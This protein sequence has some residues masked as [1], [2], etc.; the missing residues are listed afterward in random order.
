MDRATDP[1]AA[2]QRAASVIGRQRVGSFG[3]SMPVAAVWRAAF[4]MGLITSTLSTVIMALGSGRIGTNVAYRFMELATIGLRDAAI[5]YEPSWYVVLVGIINH[6]V[7]DIAWAL[8]FFGLASRW[9]LRIRP[10]TLLALTL[11]WAA[12]TAA[13][14]YYVILP[15]LQPLVIMQTPYWLGLTVHL[16]SGMAYLSFL[17]LRKPLLG[18]DE[19]A[20]FGRRATA[21]LTGALVALALV[22]A[23]GES[24]REPPWPL[25]GEQA[26][27]FD[28]SF[29]RSMAHHHAVG[30]EMARLAAEGSD[31]DEV[32]TLGRLMVGSQLAE[33]DRLRVWWRSWYGG[34]L[35]MPSLAEHAAMPGMP[36]AGD[37]DELRGLRGPALE[38]RFI[39]LMTLHHRGA[40]QMSDEACERA[41][42]P[43]LCIFA[44][45]VRYAQS[46]QIERMTALRDGRATEQATGSAD[47]DE[48]GQGILP[49]QA[50]G[51]A[52]HGG[53]ARHCRTSSGP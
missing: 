12:L 50:G 32:R 20:A 49:V 25:A 15:W 52:G 43:R 18:I 46:R 37:F 2:I 10:A 16:S 22:A 31:S 47:C 1:G 28:G 45:Q 34:E 6:Q 5:Q 33:I 48:P 27:A 8:I 41:G 23:L 53:S 13:I 19:A 7:A 4:V 42:D 17:W 30:A 38:A 51:H 44:E 21:A 39:E 40:I 9:T 36:P 14:E 26:R 29:M 11:P 3:L 24:G 35:P